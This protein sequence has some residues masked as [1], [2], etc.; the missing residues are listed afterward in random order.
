MS[1]PDLVE[2]LRK[3]SANRELMTTRK[4]P[5]SSAQHGVLAGGAGAEVGAGHEDRGAGVLR[6][7]EHE[8]RLVGPPGDEEAVLEAGAG[9]PLEVLGRDDLVGVDVRPAQRGG[10]AGVGGEGVHRRSD[11]QSFRSA[12]AVSFPVRAVAAATDGDTRWVRPPLPCRPWKLRLL[13][14]AD[15]SPGLS[16][17]GFMPR[18]IEQPAPRHSA[19]ASRKT[20]SRPS[21][22]A[23]ALTRHRA[24]DDEH[25]GVGVDVLAA[26]QL[27]GD[28]Q[29]L[30]PAVGAGAEED[31]V[32]LDLAQRGAGGQA[33]VGQR[34][35]GGAALALV[36]EVR[37]VGDGAG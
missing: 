5:S 7:V 36:G 10:G 22:S 32:D 11:S 34:L 31:G 26:Q 3:M 13:V 28:P 30:D 27:G 4:P 37:R 8:V 18:H 16:W 6:L 29:V 15:R 2:L 24:G 1:S 20:R 35:L 23:C 19:P 14:E 17:S 9:D 25:P 21:A 33:H 12:G